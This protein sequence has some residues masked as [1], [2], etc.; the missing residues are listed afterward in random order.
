MTSNSNQITSEVFSNRAP[1]IS[2]STSPGLRELLCSHI[3]QYKHKLFLE[4][5]LYLEKFL[6]KS[7]H[8]ASACWTEQP[9]VSIAMC[10]V[11][12]ALSS[13]R[14]SRGECSQCEMGLMSIRSRP[15]MSLPNPVSQNGF[16]LF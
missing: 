12:I 4:L 6:P 3:L 14:K 16:P 15:G 8:L 11:T 2:N 13:F 1:P 9:A 5:S 7:H 10:N